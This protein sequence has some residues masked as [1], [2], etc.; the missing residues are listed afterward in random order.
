MPNPLL[1]AADMAAINTY[2]RAHPEARHWAYMTARSTGGCRGYSCSSVMVL[3][4]V[5][6]TEEMFVHI[7]L[8]LLHLTVT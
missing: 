3:E 7:E 1:V 5:T 6:I 4:P 8:C 2:Q